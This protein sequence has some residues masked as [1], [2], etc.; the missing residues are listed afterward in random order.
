MSERDA[1]SPSTSLHCQRLL[2]MVSKGQAVNTGLHDVVHFG[3]QCPALQCFIYGLITCG[4]LS[5]YNRTSP[6]SM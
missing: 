5:L 3:A 2:I 1:V 4:Q 6:H